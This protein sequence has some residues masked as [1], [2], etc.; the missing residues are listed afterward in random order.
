MSLALLAFTSGDGVSKPVSAQTTASDEPA[1]D[2]VSPDAA[3]YILQIGDEIEIKVFQIPELETSGRIRP[4]GKISLMLL[5]EV[6]A[7][8][9]TTSELDAFLTDRYSQFYRDPQLTVIVRNFANLNVFVGGEVVEPGLLSLTG[10]LTALGAVLRAG[11]FRDTASMSSVILLRNVEDKPLVVRLN[12]KDVINKG[13]G[14]V[15]LRPYDVVFVPKKFIA[16]ANLFVQQYMRALLPIA[17][18]ANFTYILGGT[19]VIP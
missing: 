4:D 15:V 2:E 12:L 14:D 3:P 8:G 13:E 9:L 10:E 7:A 5:D 6:H 16:K 11:G 18:T 1:T 17:T 19:A